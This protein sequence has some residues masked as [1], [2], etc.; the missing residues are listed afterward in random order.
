MGRSRNYRA[1]ADDEIFTNPCGY[2]GA[3]L[4][5][6]R[7]VLMLALGHQHSLPRGQ[8]VTFFRTVYCRP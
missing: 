5:G 4:G 3:V 2:D 1:L 6:G 7:A 8:S